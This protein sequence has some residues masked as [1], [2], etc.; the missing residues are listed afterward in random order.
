MKK[1]LAIIAMAGCLAACNNGTDS[2]TTVSDSATV[3][4][5]S[6]VDSATIMNTTVDTTTSTAPAMDSTTAGTSAANA[7][8]AGLGTTKVDS[9]H[10]STTVTHKHK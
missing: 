10:K 7:S 4:T 5:P 3:A 9:T 8:T 2:S 6:T 1:V